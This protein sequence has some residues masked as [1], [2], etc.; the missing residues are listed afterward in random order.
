MSGS[1]SQ[2][3]DPMSV[4][5]MIEAA[6]FPR[7]A[8]RLIE[9]LER[10]GVPWVRYEDG[11]P[12]EAFPPE[13]AGVIFWGSLGAAYEQRVAARWTPGAIGDPDRFRCSVYQPQLGGMVANADAVF[14][15]VRRLV[16]EPATVLA[17]L[18]DPA[19]VFVRPDSAVKPFAGRA[20][21]VAGLSRAALDHG[22]YYDDDELPVVVGAVK[23]IGHEWRFVVADGAVVA[24]CGY[25]VS[26]QGRDLEVPGAARALA[27]RVAGE[28]WQAAPLY[29]VDV[30][31]V[32]DALRVME[33]NPFSGA[34]LYDCDPE[35]V[36]AAGTRVAARLHASEPGRAP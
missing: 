25:D 30:G 2:A 27:D 35:A 29:V 8:P 7:T 34:D 26:R 14:T 11:Q 17:R 21:A 19:R 33:L 15:T 32:D 12:A 3:S 10:R 36:I 9:A 13:G 6:V 18:G 28:A 4:T 16:D 1:S 24:G 23:R 31:E 22:F 20:L 5:W